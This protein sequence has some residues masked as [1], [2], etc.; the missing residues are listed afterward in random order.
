VLWG[1]IVASAIN[2]AFDMLVNSG[3]LF[4]GRIDL[5]TFGRTAASIGVNTGISMAT[6]AMTMGAGGAISGAV[7]GAAGG[8]ITAAVNSAISYG[9]GE[10]GFVADSLVQSGFDAA[11]GKDFGSSF[12]NRAKSR[13]T[14][15]SYWAGS[16]GSI[17]ASIATSALTSKIDS[18]FNTKFEG[19]PA[20][21]LGGKVLSG[22]TS[23]VVKSGISYASNLLGTTIDNAARGTLSTNVFEEAA[24]KSGIMNLSTY[25]QWGADALGT[26]G[27]HFFDNSSLGIE[28][29]EK[30]NKRKKDRQERWNKKLQPFREK[31]VSR[32]LDRIVRQTGDNTLMDMMG[33][34]SFGNDTD[35]KGGNALTIRE[36]NGDLKSILNK[37]LIGKGRLKD[38]LNIATV[39]AWESERNG[40]VTNDNSSETIRSARSRI[41][42]AKKLSGKYGTRFIRKNR[43]LASLALANKNLSKDDFEKYVNMKFSST[44]DFSKI[45]DGIGDAENDPFYNFGKMLGIKFF[46]KDEK[47]N[48][49]M[50]EM[51]GG[52]HRKYTNEYLEFAKIA[53]VKDARQNGKFSIK[54]NQ[55]FNFNSR[56]MKKFIRKYHGNDPKKLAEIDKKYGTNYSKGLINDSGNGFWKKTGNVLFNL[57]PPVALYKSAK[58][59]KGKL[60][61]R[62][63]LNNSNDGY[64]GQ[65][66]IDLWGGND[67]T[68]NWG[69]RTAGQTNALIGAYKNQKKRNPNLQK[70][71]NLINGYTKNGKYG[72]LEPYQKSKKHGGDKLYSNGVI[73]ISNGEDLQYMN[74]LSKEIG[75]EGTWSF[76]S[77]FKKNEY[78]LFIQQYKDLVKKNK[79]PYVIV[80]FDTGSNYSH[81]DYSYSNQ[82]GNFNIVDSYGGKSNVRSM[83]DINTPKPQSYIDR[84]N[85]ADDDKMGYWKTFTGPISK[86]DITVGCIN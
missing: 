39:L 70:M 2:G 31:R 48:N 84:Y 54:K 80:T 81:H 38:V 45:S 12:A 49:V 27:Q 36:E 60:K 15:G 17:G 64:L 25:M 7:Q 47:G 9:M 61:N 23:S 13:Y 75:V 5:N 14:S 77:R 42:M 78:K 85:I 43:E 53:G 24:H 11:E 69:C 55:K 71:K 74:E 19:N 46:E 21:L 37:S 44:N 32:I 72:F 8:V 6:S 3:D 56:K 20:A 1:G 4:T 79:D 82:G 50:I 26:V 41:A 16:L 34:F 57:L 59:I 22:F 65:R 30:R 66:D 33:Q 86:S 67:S 83:W 35:T 62:N 76:D 63:K 29:N 68:I 58:Y 51:D 73:Y 28:M 40:V 52:S 10:V 18:S